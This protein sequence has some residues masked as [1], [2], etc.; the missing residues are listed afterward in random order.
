MAGAPSVRRR[1]LPLHA[2]PAPARGLHGLRCPH[3][4]V[5]WLLP[6]RSDF[7]MNFWED[8]TQPKAGLFFVALMSSCPAWSPLRGKVS[9]GLEH[10]GLT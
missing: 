1:S 9:Q 8:K 6:R 3:L 2:G 5:L 10:K 7:S 4:G